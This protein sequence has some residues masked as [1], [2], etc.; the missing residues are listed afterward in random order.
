MS[1]G[2]TVDGEGLSCMDMC[3][4]ILGSWGHGSRKKFKRL[5]ALRSH[6]LFYSYR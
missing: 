2:A 4:V 5:E 1:G 3:M 6:F